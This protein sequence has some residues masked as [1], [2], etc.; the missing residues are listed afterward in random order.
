VLLFLAVLVAAG[1]FFAARDVQDGR[2]LG[3]FSYMRENAVLLWFA[4]KI[5]KDPIRGTIPGIWGEKRPV[6]DKNPLAVLPST[7]GIV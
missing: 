7:A 5:P 6:G 3:C 4:G 2:F 1:Q